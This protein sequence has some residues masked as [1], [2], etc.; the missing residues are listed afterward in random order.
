ME[1]RRK[2]FLALSAGTVGATILAACGGDSNNS[3]STGSSADT[4]TGDSTEASAPERADAD[5]VI[6]T[7][8]VKA[9]ALQA[10]AA[11]WG[12]ANGLSVAVQAVA[13]ELQS[14]FI[15]ANDAGNGPD[16]ILA[17]HDWMGNLV[18]NGSIS[19]VPLSASASSAVSEVALKGAQYEGQNYGLPFATESLVLFANKSLT[20]TPAPKSIEELVAAG[21]A[22]GAENILSLPVGEEGDA[23][24]M[25]PLYTSAGG[26]L[27]GT[28]ADGDPD[29]KDVGVGKEGSLA[30]AEKI[31]ELGKAG[32]LKKSISGDNAISLFTEGK[33]AYLISGPW[34]LS[35]IKAA[36]IDYE[37]SPIP[38]F[39]G[40][41]PAQPFAGVVLFYVASKGANAINAQTFIQ[42][43]SEDNTLIGEMFLE[44]QLPPVNTELQD[45]LKGEYPDIVNIASIANAA[46]P[47]P[48]IPA[49][50]AV[51]QPLGL[52]YANI[53]GGAD[54]A[55]TMQSAGEEIVKAI[56]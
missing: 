44:N 12:E 29:P 15:T 47:M 10:P 21:E 19:P 45:Q 40:M 1:I 20:D 34:A 3:N 54:P 26:Y 5:L 24:H 55:S 13:Q 22:G 16:I 30:A 23:Y 52:A 14:S 17:A 46:T 50:A 38:G 27:F 48:A 53:V 25:Q 31:S 35:D 37:M 9:N 6:W 36:G 7:D 2:S 8:D 28:T 4:S 49:M 39:E 42:S 18:Q 41:N 32:V 51:W 11:K 43:I 33:A 56:G